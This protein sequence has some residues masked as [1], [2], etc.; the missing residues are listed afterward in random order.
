VPRIS[1]WKE[2]DVHQG[3]VLFP[4]HQHHAY[5]VGVVGISRV[6]EPRCGDIGL[7]HAGHPADL[8]HP[9]REHEVF[10][11]IVTHVVHLRVGFMCDEG[12]GR[13]LYPDI[14]ADLR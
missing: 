12:L 6:V 5:A 10:H 13:Q 14:A 3:Y 8:D 7:P 9:A 1:P 11:D 4:H 2:L